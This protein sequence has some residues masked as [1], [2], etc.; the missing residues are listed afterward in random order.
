M[1]GFEFQEM[2][3]LAADETPYRKLTS[4]FVATEKKN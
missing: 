2:F 4:D 1:A 3:P